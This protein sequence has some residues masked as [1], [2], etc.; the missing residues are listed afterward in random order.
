LLGLVPATYYYQAQPASPENLH[1]VRW[2]AW[3]YIDC[4]FYGVRK[5][6]GWLAAPGQP[7]RRAALELGM[8]QSAVRT[9][10]HRL[11]QQYAEIL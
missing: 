2:V 7:V 5:M 1:Y 11:R 4:P 9:A 10:V 3:A 6:T 8:S